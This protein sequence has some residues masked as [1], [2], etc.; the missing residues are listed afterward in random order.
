VQ[1]PV[2]HLLAQAILRTHHED[3]ISSLFEIQF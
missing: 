2:A 1:L 3:S